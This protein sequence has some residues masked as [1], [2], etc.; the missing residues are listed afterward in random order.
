MGLIRVCF[1]I[2]TLPEQYL[3]AL[4][5]TNRPCYC[6]HVMSSSLIHGD[7]GDG[8]NFVLAPLVG[9]EAARLSPSELNT[10]C[11]HNGIYIFSIN[12]YQLTG[13]LF[14]YFLMLPTHPR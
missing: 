6:I 10:T 11:V 1:I 4:L 13:H 12:I 5:L 8:F 7:L 14:N 3:L 2:Y 9:S